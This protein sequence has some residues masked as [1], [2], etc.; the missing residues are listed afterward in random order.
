[1]E[2][3]PVMGLM[4]LLFFFFSG[5]RHEEDEKE[6]DRRIST[7]THIQTIFKFIFY[8]RTFPLDAEYAHFS[9][10]GRGKCAMGENEMRRPPRSVGDLKQPCC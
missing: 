2:G 9:M 5:G 4:L 8:G 3:A 10:S 6:E 1:M 7:S